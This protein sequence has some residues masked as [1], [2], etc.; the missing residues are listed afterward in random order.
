L[1]TP[2][3]RYPRDEGDL[4]WT[5]NYDLGISLAQVKAKFLRAN[6]FLFEEI[7]TT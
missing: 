3:G 4:H 2:D 6:Q 7:G 5:M 1:P